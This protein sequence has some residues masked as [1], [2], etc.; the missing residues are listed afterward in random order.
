MEDRRLLQDLL[1]VRP[2][3]P[4]HYDDAYFNR[5]SAVCLAYGIDDTQRSAVLETNAIQYAKFDRGIGVNTK[6][7][8]DVP[9][10]GYSPARPGALY[11]VPVRPHI[12][13]QQQFEEEHVSYYMERT[14]GGTTKEERKAAKEERKA[15]KRTKLLDELTSPPSRCSSFSARS[16]ARRARASCGRSSS[17]TASWSPTTQSTWSCAT[18]AFARDM[19]RRSAR[20]RVRNI[21]TRD[22]RAEEMT[23]LVFACVD[24]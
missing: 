9:H 15:A 18:L 14:H 7:R 23:R 21:C 12:T 22:R 17:S 3:D 6:S 11:A 24:T 13:T 16:R 1:G 10:D 8:H 5:D 2:R 20:D 19:I 4:A